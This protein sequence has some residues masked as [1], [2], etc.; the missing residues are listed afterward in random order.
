MPVANSPPAARRRRVLEAAAG[1]R[2]GQPSGMALSAAKRSRQYAP[3]SFAAGASGR[4]SCC[5]ATWLLALPL[6]VK[7][8]L[9]WAAPSPPVELEES[10]A[11]M[12]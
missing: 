8:T 11:A 5:L 12:G 9:T 2:V 6:A 1:Y 4:R 3:A 7:P 10:K